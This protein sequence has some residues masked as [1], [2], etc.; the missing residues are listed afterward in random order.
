MKRLLNFLNIVGTG[1]LGVVDAF[2][3][4]VDAIT[5]QR[6]VTPPRGQFEGLGLTPHADVGH[7]AHKN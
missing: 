4:G 7:S 2:W 6:V 3:A 1:V 5:R